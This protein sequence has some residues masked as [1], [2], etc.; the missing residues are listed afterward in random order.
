MA[1]L[2]NLPA[3]QDT[4][5]VCERTPIGVKSVNL[6][7]NQ[8]DWEDLARQA[9]G[10]QAPAGRGINGI[11]RCGRGGYRVV[12]NSWKRSSFDI[13]AAECQRAAGLAAAVMRCH[14]LSA[15]ELAVSIVFNEGVAGPDA[16]H[17]RYT[18]DSITISIGGASTV[19]Q[20]RVSCSERVC[21]FAYLA[22][23]SYT[24]DPEPAILLEYPNKASA[25]TIYQGSVRFHGMAPTAVTLRL[26]MGACS[27]AFEAAGEYYRRT[28]GP[29]LQAAALTEPAAVG[30][31]VVV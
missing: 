29:A 4:F 25:V 13:S 31:W 11:S 22:D 30:A 7:A 6:V 3:R 26:D 16:D 14:A 19:L 10:R 1:A 5:V 23:R 21:E 17:L 15:T 9:T 12:A 8:A 28:V 2:Y 20:L 27:A 18:C 24:D